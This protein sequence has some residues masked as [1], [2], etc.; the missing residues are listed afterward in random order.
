MSIHSDHAREAERVR[1]LLQTA[2][3]HALRESGERVRAGQQEVE[4]GYEAIGRQAASALEAG[5]NTSEIAEAAGVSRA[6]IYELREKHGGGDRALS[7]RIL[8][9]LAAGGGSTVDDLAANLDLGSAEAAAAVEDLLARELIRVGFTAYDEG[10]ATASFL[11]ISESGLDQVEQWIERGGEA[12]R[13]LSV[14]VA[15]AY[16]EKEAIRNV[17]IDVLGPELFAVIEPD[18]TSDPDQGLELGFKV[19]ADD[20]DQAVQRAGEKMRLMR[21]LAKVS[22][23]PTRITAIV[24]VEY[25]RLPRRRAHLER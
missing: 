14:Y 16:E 23:R 20:A 21:K 2:A 6:K 19:V 15:I 8:T 17:A 1:N 11:C 24:P 18:L 13:Q 25:Q 9:E 5:L 3:R 7:M 22:D 12:P 10:K 4:L